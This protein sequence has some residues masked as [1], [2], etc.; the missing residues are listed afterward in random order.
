MV[1]CRAGLRPRISSQW[2]S[3][4]LPQQQAHQFMDNRHYPWGRH[5]PMVRTARLPRGRL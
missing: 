5:R 1:N 4:V 3:T 2:R